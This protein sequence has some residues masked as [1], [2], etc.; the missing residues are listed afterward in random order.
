MLS[1]GSKK[2]HESSSEAKN[3]GSEFPFCSQIFV[4]QMF[5]TRSE[6]F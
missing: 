2:Q 4:L 5:T 3:Q 6:Q 1:T